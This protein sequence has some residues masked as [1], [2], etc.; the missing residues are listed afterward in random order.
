MTPEV[1]PPSEA[2]AIAALHEF[3]ALWAQ[4]VNQLAAIMKTASGGLQHLALDFIGR[5]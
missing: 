1:S 4:P 3:S 2:D 5:C